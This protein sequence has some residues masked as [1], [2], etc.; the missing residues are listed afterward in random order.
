MASTSPT[1]PTPDAA[2]VHEPPAAF[3]H[4]LAAQGLNVLG[5]VSGDAYDAA[6]PT[7]FQR[8]AVHPEARSAIIVASGGRALWTAIGRAPEATH[9]HRINEFT[10]RVITESAAAHLTPHAGPSVCLW[11]NDLRDGAFVPIIGLAVAAGIGT[12]GR[13]MLLLNPT[14]GMWIGLRGVVLTPAELTP[15]RGLAEAGFDPCTGCHAPCASVCHGG[16][17]TDAGYDG[18]ACITTRMTRRACRRTCDARY[19]CPVGAEHGYSAEQMAHHAGH[20]LSPRTMARFLWFAA[21]RRLA[22]AVGRRP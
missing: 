11:P 15:T 17:I 2:A 9:I 10:Q 13:M 6:C 14:Y 20:L 21:G 19:A 16:V 18:A 3:T 4:A 7:A 12:P 5:V 8:A 1:T 22:A